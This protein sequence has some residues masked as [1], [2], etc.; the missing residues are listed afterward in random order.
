M[1]KCNYNYSIIQFSPF[2]ER[3]EYV[4]LGVLVFDDR[5][6]KVSQK[7]A[8]DF[9]RVK[10]IFG[11]VNTS[12]LNMALHD[13]S[14]RIVFEYNQH[15]FSTFSV[16]NFNDKRADLFRLTPVNS[17]FST[18]ATH[19]TETLYDELIA[20]SPHVKR[21]ERVNK[22]LSDAFSKAGVLQLL[23]K[24]PEPIH[25]EQYGVNIQADFGYQN[26]FY[27]LID[28][29]RFDNPQRALAEAGKRVL[30][31]RAIAE[32]QNKRLIVVAEFGN[33]SDQ[34]VGNLKDDFKRAGSKLFRLEE[35][36]ELADEIKK[37][38]H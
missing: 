17:V 38:S 20:L 21:I 4:N 35:V 32:L 37:A 14:Q 25:I 23:D 33:Q 30:E 6:G 18:S 3:Y 7:I 29:A 10:K 15:Q 5:R 22:L 28:A 13:F 2:P 34:F 24:R 19:A 26:G 36:E 16:D 1:N 11:E 12:F 27:N 31:G 8:N 9:G